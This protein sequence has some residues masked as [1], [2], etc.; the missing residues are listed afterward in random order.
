MTKFHKHAYSAITVSLF[1]VGRIYDHETELFS[2][3]KAN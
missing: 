1:E 2:I 3:K